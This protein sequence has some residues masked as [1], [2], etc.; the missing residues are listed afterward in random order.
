MEEIKSKIELTKAINAMLACL[1]NKNEL[2]CKK[3]I[4][5]NN[6]DACCFLME[7]VCVYKYSGK[8]KTNAEP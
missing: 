2:N 4:D 5:C 8:N 1:L 7:A 6:V 3:C